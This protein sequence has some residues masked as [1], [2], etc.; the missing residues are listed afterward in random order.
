MRIASPERW[1]RLD[2]ACLDLPVLGFAA[3][4]ALL[5]TVLAGLLP[6]WLS[7]GVDLAS[8]LRDGEPRLVCARRGLVW[9]RA[10]VQGGLRSVLVNQ[11]LARA[12]FPGQQAVGKRL[13]F[14]GGG[15][16]PSDWYTV[17]GVVA[18]HHQ[19]SLATPPGPELYRPLS[20]ELRPRQDL[21]IRTRSAPRSLVPV[22]Q[23]ILQALDP[24][25]PLM[26]TLTL[27][28][29]VSR[30]LG[31]DRFLTL[32]MLAFGFLGLVLAGL[33]I[34]GVTSFSVTLRTA[35]IGT[36][37]ALGADRRMITR[38]FIK[39]GAGL[40]ARGLVLGIPAA[41]L[42]GRWLGPLLFEVEPFDFGSLAVF[43]ALMVAVGAGASW[44]PAHR[45]A[46]IDP[47]FTL[48]GVWG[49]LL[50]EAAREECYAGSERDEKRGMSHQAP[51]QTDR[52]RKNIRQLVGAI[53]AGLAIE[54][55]RDSNPSD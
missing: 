6:A 30:S 53:H 42:L 10:E 41:L 50:R 51:A 19:A 13:A 11:T 54:P 45:A 29:L 23:D 47:A 55:V 32:L 34:Y 20:Q 36:R 46:C 2:E 38:H 22:V 16:P 17:V 26:R 12:I 28:E 24:N 8:A 18:D 25:L 9:G 35:E 37:M 27:E 48:H 15:Q 5:S 31:R 40:A 7:S 21:V 43:G 33:G 52:E 44:V 3:G 1:P 4:V 14:G 39:E 49:W